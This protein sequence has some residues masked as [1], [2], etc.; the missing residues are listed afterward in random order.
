MDTRV[1][2]IN[3]INSMRGHH[4]II[5]SKLHRFLH[6]TSFRNRL[7]DNDDIADDNF[8][9]TI[10]TNSGTNLKPIM[11]LEADKNAAIDALRK[12]VI[13]KLIDISSPTSPDEQKLFE[14]SVQQKDYTRVILETAIEWDHQ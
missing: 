12:K 10:S 6:N 9:S 2:A 11:S 8:A 14:N 5:C 4:I 13:R 1:Q 3:S 7:A